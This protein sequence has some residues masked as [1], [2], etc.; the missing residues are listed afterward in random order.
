[1]AGE[2]LTTHS[3]AIPNILVSWRIEGPYVRD[4]KWRFPVTGAG[5]PDDIIRC[6]IICPMLVPLLISNL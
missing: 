6:R 1:M 3:P 5:Q 4:G 2:L